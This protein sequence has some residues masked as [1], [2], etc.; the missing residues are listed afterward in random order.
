MSMFGGLAGFASSALQQAGTAFGNHR[1]AAISRDFAERMSSTAHQR[2]VADLR[3]AGLNPILSATGGSGS[4][5]PNGATAQIGGPDMTSSAARASEVIAQNRIRDKQEKLLDT[6]N[7]LTASQLHKTNLEARVL[8]PVASAAYYQTNFI[9][10]S[11]AVQN[12]IRAGVAADLGGK[13]GNSAGSLIGSMFPAL[14]QRYVEF[15]KKL[16]VK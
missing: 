1:E 9:N 6:Q 2:E 3:A 5:T 7:Q 14:H 8:D 11:K 12:M 4:S 10:S 16:G 13:I 15:G